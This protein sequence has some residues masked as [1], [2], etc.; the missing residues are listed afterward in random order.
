VD[1][2]N[3]RG[4]LRKALP[5]TTTALLVAVLAGCGDGSGEQGGPDE[6]A[7]QA[8]VASEAPAAPR[9]PGASGKMDQT[10]FW[11]LITD[12]R[13]AAGNDTGRQSELLEERLRQLPAQSI[14]E[15]QRIRHQLDAQA[16]TWDLW[17]AASVI[18]DGCSDD[19][20]RDFRAY[21]ISLGRR[22]YEAALRDPDTLAPVVQDA[23]EGGWENADSVAP[24]AYEEVAGE[25]IPGGDSD[26]SGDPRGERW[27]FE[28]EDALV[29]RYPRLAERFR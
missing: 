1:T 24:D 28:N 23:E 11:S 29:R 18:E 27:D 25:E 15:F 6:R 7:S 2:P 20:Y 4:P 12:T 5:A 22:P 8:P 3:R 16:Y 14:A 13:Q 21:L 10:T 19:C 26:L 17:A 9:S